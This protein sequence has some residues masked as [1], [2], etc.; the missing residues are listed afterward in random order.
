M[1]L[2]PNETQ[3]LLW[4]CLTLLG[5]LGFV[6]ALAVHALMQMGKDLNE[7]KISLKEVATKH[8][9][10]E[11]RVERLENHVFDN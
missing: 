2:T 3:F 10:T 9:A 8:D 5:M 6:G 4:A 1:N 11:K 7:I